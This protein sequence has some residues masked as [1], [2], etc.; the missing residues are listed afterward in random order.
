MM[1]RVKWR[2]GVK[3]WVMGMRALVGM[4]KGYIEEK[5]VRGEDNVEWSVMASTI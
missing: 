1:V 2:C 3:G 5:G 4:R